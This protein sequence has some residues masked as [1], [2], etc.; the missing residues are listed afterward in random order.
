[1]NHVKQ[2]AIRGILWSTVENATVRGVTFLTF[3]VMARLLDSEAFGL[4]AMATVYVSFLELV[5]RVGITDALVQT[6]ELTDEHKDSVFWATA[7][8]GAICMTLSIALAPLIA[9]LAKQPDLKLVIIVLAIG[10]IPLS[11]TRVQEGLLLRSMKFRTLAVRQSVTAITGAATGIAMA[12]SGFGVWS[13]VGQQLVSRVVDFFVLYRLTDWRPGF[14]FSTTHLRELAA[15]SSRVLGTNIVDF[16]A[17]E[18]DKLIIGYLFGPATLG[19]YVVGQRLALVAQL[20]LRSVFNRVIF[21]A[22]SR[23]QSELALVRDIYRVTLTNTGIISLPLFTLLALYGSEIVPV[24]FGA[25]W[26]ESGLICQLFGLGGLF[27][28]LAL[29]AI[30]T[31]KALGFPELALKGVAIRAAVAPVLM[32]ALSPYGIYLVACVYVLGECFM[33]AYFSFWLDRKLHLKPLQVLKFLTPPAAATAVAS[34]ALLLIMSFDSWLQPVGAIYR[35]SGTI[36]LYLAA[37]AIALIVFRPDFAQALT[38]RITGIAEN[39]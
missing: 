31:L 24:V 18:S 32:F 26:T 9:L 10:T 14:R 17:K 8:L 6:R 22:Q 27:C 21:S 13:L 15:Y 11:L 33:A 39:R 20:S 29:P 36:L 28:C 23:L 19:L 5:V 2:S 7:A 34:G 12:L 16:F 37:Y 25:K 1:M 3:M 38:R 4:V 30:P 35:V